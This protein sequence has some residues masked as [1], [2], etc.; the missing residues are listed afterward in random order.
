MSSNVPRRRILVSAV[1]GM[2]C[3]PT[4]GLAQPRQRLYRVGVLFISPDAGLWSEFVA[5]LARRGYVEGTNIVFEKRMMVVDQ[6]GNLDRFAAELANAK[7]DVIFTGPSRSALAAKRATSTIPI[8]FLATTDPVAMGLV[9]NLSHP[10]GNVTGGW[11]EDWDVNARE[12]QLLAQVSGKVT[13]FAYVFP[14]GG[15]PLPALADFLSKTA[16]AL[17]MRVQF[18]YY[19]SEQEL[20]PLMERLVRE[21]VDGVG[22][23]WIAPT[24]DSY[25]KLPEML[26]R[27]RLPSLGNAPDGYLLSYGYSDSAIARLAARQVDQVLKGV[28][29]ADIPIEQISSFELE[30]NLRTAKAL[31]LS[32]PTSVLVQAT[33]LIE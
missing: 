5:E 17:G 7:V 19:G 21:G 13:N 20:G 1:A 25:R 27:L 12:L 29:P 2:S 16:S 22:V 31:G 10:G 28:R 33:R 32:I 18:S 9:R 30:I 24:S 4:V 11:K 15:R 14:R 8:V 23:S 26:I 3:W 6:V